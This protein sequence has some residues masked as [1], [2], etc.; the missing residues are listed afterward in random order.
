[1]CQGSLFCSKLRNSEVFQPAR[2]RM[3]LCLPRR[4]WTEYQGAIGTPQFVWLGCP[5]AVLNVSEFANEVINSNDES[6]GSSGK[7]RSSKV[8]EENNNDIGM[9]WLKRRVEGH[10]P[11]RL[12]W[13][14]GTTMAGEGG[15]N[16]VGGGGAMNLGKLFGRIKKTK[17]S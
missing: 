6:D 16:T 4:L 3:L 11:Q 8:S 12:Q 15:K 1:M 7:L 5:A 14:G 10:P 9:G 13:L 17:G 2:R